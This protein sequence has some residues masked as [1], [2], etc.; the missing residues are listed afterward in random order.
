LARRALHGGGVRRGVLGA[1]MHRDARRACGRREFRGG[2]FAAGGCGGRKERRGG[3]CGGLRAR[4][5]FAGRPGIAAGWLRVRALG[6][7]SRLGA[8]GRRDPR[9]VGES[10]GSL[11]MTLNSCR[12]ILPTRR[13]RRFASRRDRA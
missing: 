13:G 11:Q 9:E 8:C 2:G 5:L 1:G 4:R 7:E 3:G 6:G 12:D 10:G